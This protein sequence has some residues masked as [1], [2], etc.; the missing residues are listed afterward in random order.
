MFYSLENYLL[1][2]Q[3]E[4]SLSTVMNTSSLQESKYLLEHLLSLALSRGF[5]CT[6]KEA[7]YKELCARYEKIQ[8][9]TKLRDQ[10]LDQVLKDSGITLQ[11]H[12]DCEYMILISN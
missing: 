6:Q 8:L 1:F 12:M 2:L 9:D 11:S 10:L 5:D 4:T 7:Q 3:D